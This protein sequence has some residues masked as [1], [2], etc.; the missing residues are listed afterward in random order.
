MATSPLLAYRVSGR[1]T[2]LAAVLGLVRLVGRSVRSELQR[3]PARVLEL[4]AHVGRDEVAGLDPLEPVPLQNLPV[5]CFQ[6]SPGNSTGPEIDVSPPLLAHRLLNRDVC[7]LD[8]PAR[9]EHAED[10]G[11]DRILVGNQVDDPVRD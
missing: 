3:F 7:D 10:L 9:L 1:F 4:R 6:Q 5:L 2:S 11:E 8:P